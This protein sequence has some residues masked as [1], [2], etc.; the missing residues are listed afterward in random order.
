MV[1]LPFHARFWRTDRD[2]GEGCLA[3]LMSG[4]S[5]F[6]ESRLGAHA[7]VVSTRIGVVARLEQTAHRPEEEDCRMYH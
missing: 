2:Q 3:Q 5:A 1:I 6:P 7:I 4:V